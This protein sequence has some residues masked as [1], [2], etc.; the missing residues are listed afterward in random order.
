M[1]KKFVIA[2]ADQQIV[3]LNNVK[4]FIAKIQEKTPYL[5]SYV[6][7]HYVL[8]N[9]QPSAYVQGKK[10]NIFLGEMI[11]FSRLS[12]RF[13]VLA[14]DTL[15]EKNGR[16]V[17]LSQQTTAVGPKG[18]ET[19]YRNDAIS[20]PYEHLFYPGCFIKEV[21]RDEIPCF[22]GKKFVHSDIRKFIG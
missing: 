5:V 20:I 1:N 18:R 11:S 10:N 12:V 6:F 9:G 8:P 15:Y 2:Y 4:E 17:N 3:Y 7:N 19:N 13:K 21:P 22:I 16:E 14:S